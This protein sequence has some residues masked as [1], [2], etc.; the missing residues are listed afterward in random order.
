MY[1]H[2]VRC[3]EYLDRT[4]VEGVHLRYHKDKQFTNFGDWLQVEAWTP[5][6]IIMTAFVAHSTH[7]T[8]R[9]AEVL[10]MPEEAKRWDAKAAQVRAAF[11]KA[12]LRP[13]GRVI[14]HRSDEDTQTG[15]LLA[16][17]F[18]LL[19][20]ERRA[21][22]FARL[23]EAIAAKNHHLTT[24][25]VGLPYLLPVLTRFGRADIAY[26]L[27]MN[28]TYPS[29]L[30]P[31]TQGATTIWERWNGWKKDEGPA[32]PG[33]NSYSHYAYGA[34]GEWL[35]SDCAGI[36]LAAVAFKA[37]RIHPR[38]GGGLTRA[39]ATHECIYGR[40]AS[41]WSVAEGKVRL[42]VEIPPNTTARIHVPT[43]DPASLVEGGARW[44]GA[45]ERE[46]QSVVV[47]V[48]SG[49]YDFSAAWAARSAAAG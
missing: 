15:Y 10:G 36:D 44:T 13:D 28:K 46:V 16:L 48:G 32:D 6:E 45:V 34:V 5:P 27:L 4:S 14:G 9:A 39:E 12:F 42:E 1:P 8:A 24:G 33:M 29:W 3:V 19:P 49:R 41:R 38:I 17:H 18:D 26:R 43:S 25:F 37:I 30:Y 11:T 47:S 7:L 23:I 21:Q 40:I 35:F 22:A 2:M 20:E 31:V